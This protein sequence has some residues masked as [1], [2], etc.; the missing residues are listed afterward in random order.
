M[1]KIFTIILI[2]LLSLPGTFAQLEK[3]RFLI[4]FDGNYT[5]RTNESFSDI[6]FLENKSLNLNPSL[7][8]G[9]SKNFTVGV[10]VD[11][12]WDKQIS[13]VIMG[14]INDPFSLS[15]LIITDISKSYSPYAFLGYYYEIFNRLYIGGQLHLK[16][17]FNHEGERRYYKGTTLTANI[18]PEVNYFISKYFTLYLALGKAGYSWTKFDDYDKKSWQIDF[19][20]KYWTLGIRVAI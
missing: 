17:G 16:F 12:T 9:L 15:Q 14:N 18:V 11:L 3:G 19:N 20:P 2:S 6:D 7:G 4:S 1:K 5:K 8:I 10:G 13:T